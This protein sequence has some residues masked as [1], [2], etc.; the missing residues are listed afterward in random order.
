VGFGNFS[1]HVTEIMLVDK[2]KIYFI[3]D[4]E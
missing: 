1:L 4:Y 3:N 2:H